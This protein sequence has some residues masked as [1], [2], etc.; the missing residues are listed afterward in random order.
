VEEPLA[1]II[2][3]TITTNTNKLLHKCTCSLITDLEVPPT[4]STFI[5]MDDSRGYNPLSGE[6]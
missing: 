4:V 2:I 6:E 3:T 5:V 1:T